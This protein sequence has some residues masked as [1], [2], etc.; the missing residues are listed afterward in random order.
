MLK[1]PLKS[2]SGAKGVQRLGI[3]SNPNQFAQSKASRPEILKKKNALNPVDLL[4]AR[5]K[6]SETL[7]N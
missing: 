7:I 4:R 1:Y 6:T 5:G 3:L 2:F